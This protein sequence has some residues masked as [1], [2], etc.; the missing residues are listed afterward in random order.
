MPEASACAH[1]PARCQI[2]EDE[3]EDDLAL[4]PHLTTP[5]SVPQRAFIVAPRTALRHLPAR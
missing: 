4:L 1:T 2:I 3:D 5:P